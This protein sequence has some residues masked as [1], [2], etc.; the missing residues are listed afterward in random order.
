MACVR[1]TGTICELAPF[2]QLQNVEIVQARTENND[3]KPLLRI[4]TFDGDSLTL[5]CRDGSQASAIASLLDGYTRLFCD[6]RCLLSSYNSSKSDQ[7]SASSGISTNFDDDDITFEVV[8]FKSSMYYY[9]DGVML[10]ICVIYFSLARCTD[11]VT[12]GFATVRKH[13]HHR[14]VKA[15]A[16]TTNVTVL[17]Q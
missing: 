8:P 16:T 13:P 3:S 9:L 5:S 6:G 12:S 15:E 14:N 11:A 17:N 4:K 10:F 7:N 1:S 2:G